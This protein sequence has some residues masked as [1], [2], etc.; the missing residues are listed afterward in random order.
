MRRPGVDVV[1]A[2]VC[3]ALVVAFTVAVFVELGA[4]LTQPWPAP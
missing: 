1:L 3:A 4:V 2:V